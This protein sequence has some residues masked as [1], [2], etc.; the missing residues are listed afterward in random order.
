VLVDYLAD[1]AE[2]ETVVRF[3]EWCLLW[4][5]G[6]VLFCSSQGDVVARYSIP[7]LGGSPMRPWTSCLDQLGQLCSCECVQGAVLGGV[8][9]SCGGADSSRQSSPSSALMPRAVCDWSAS[10]AP[11]RVRAPAKGPRPARP[12]HHGLVVVPSEGNFLPFTFNL[13][14][15]FV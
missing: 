10:R 11:V 6:F 2:Q 8:E 3:F 9:R 15:H 4:L 1:D 14:F 7:M 13:S 12:F 5:F